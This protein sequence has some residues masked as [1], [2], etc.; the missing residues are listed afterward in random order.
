[1]IRNKPPAIAGQLDRCD[2]CG[3]KTHRH[4]LVRTQVEFLDVAAENYF[5]KSSYDGTYWV[6][7]APAYAHASAICY[8]TRCDNA[9]TT[10]SP[11]NKI[12]YV[13]GAPSWY[14]SGNIRTTVEAGPW[15]I[16]SDLTFSA[17]VG[18]CESS[19]SPDMTVTLGITSNDGFLPQPIRTWS[20]NTATRVWF[21]EEVS[22]LNDYGLGD[23]DRCFFFYIGISGQELTDTWWVDEMQLE[24]NTVTGAPGNFVS[25]NVGSGEYISNQTERILMTSRKVCPACRERILSKSERFGKTNESPQADPVEA[26]VQ[27]I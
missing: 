18:P 24:A 19:T 16:S 3:N 11:G 25:S 13:N 2:V 23:T 4:N 22:T 14:G 5:E 21:N 10:L 1:M 6:T 20:I 17:H 15:N 7:D 9:R 26:W 8:G 27:E 12:T